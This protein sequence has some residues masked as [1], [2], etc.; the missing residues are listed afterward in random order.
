MR[1]RWFMLAAVLTGCPYDPEAAGLIAV[2]GGYVYGEGDAQ[3]FIPGEVDGGFYGPDLLPEAPSIE[4]L[5]SLYVGDVRE[6][7]DYPTRFGT[8]INDVQRFYG[9]PPRNGVV[10]GKDDAKVSYMWRGEND[11]PAGL[12]LSFE[13]IPLNLVAS[14][15]GGW[16]NR[17]L[18]DSY[19]LNGIQMRDGRYLDCWRWEL[20][21][22]GYQGC[23]GC[24][25]HKDLLYCTKDNPKPT[26]CFDPTN[27]KFRTGE[28]FKDE[29]P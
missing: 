7:T 29:I 27:P 15:G 9:H 17:H 1:T 11:E 21:E 20:K 25:D 10:L 8:W 13:Y 19:W 22:P 16:S 26:D 18:N 28:K 4:L 24:I 2:D 3:V 5:C 6:M 14:S 23:P 12:T